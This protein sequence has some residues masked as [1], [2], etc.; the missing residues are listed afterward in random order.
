MVTSGIDRAVVQHGTS[1][2]CSSEAFTSVPIAQ[3]HA[4]IPAMFPRLKT[5][6]AVNATQMQPNWSH[7]P[8]L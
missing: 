4:L 5:L 3:G 6:S 8:V 7:S 1:D 2:I